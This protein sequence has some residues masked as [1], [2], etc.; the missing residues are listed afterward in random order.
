MMNTTK[1]ELLLSSFF[2]IIYQA[3]TLKQRKN[4]RFWMLIF[5]AMLEAKIKCG[6]IV[7]VLIYSPF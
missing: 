1:N 4:I 7:F 3:D 2:I 6:L 5:K